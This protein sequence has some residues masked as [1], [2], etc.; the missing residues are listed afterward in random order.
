MEKN[1]AWG[2]FELSPLN[3]G[4]SDASPD[5]AAASPEKTK[6]ATPFPSRS[7]RKAR[8][9]KAAPAA[10]EPPVSS[11][12][13]PETPR[14]IELFDMPPESEIKE[15]KKKV[16]K[17]KKEK[18]QKESASAGETG[19]AG[20]KDKKG[21]KKGLVFAL[22]GGGLLA[23]A[24]IVGVI[25]ILTF[26]TH[27]IGNGNLAAR[28][29]GE[30]ITAKQLE[31]SIAKLQLNNPQIFEKNSG[32]SAAQIRDALL[33]ELINEQL[34]L[35]DAKSKGVTPSDQQVNQ[36]VEAIKKQYGSQK[37]FD[38]VL[39]K[40]GYT[41]ESLKT[42]LKYQLAAQGIAK[43][44][45]PDSAVSAK[46]AQ[47][48]FNANKQNYVVQAGKQVSQIKFALSDQAKADEVLA[49]I[50]SGGDF[51]QLAKANS[52]D[53]VTA[54][55]G[56]DLGWTPRNPPLDKTLQE[57]VN[58]MKKGDVSDVIKSST[59]LFILKVTDEREAS[60]QPFSNVEST[61]KMTL[62]NSKRNEAS[63]SLLTDLKKKAKI[64]IYDKVVKDFQDKKATAA[65][66]TSNGSKSK[67][68]GSG[69]K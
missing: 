59:G 15:K 63:R 35:Q 62:L 32:I 4:P 12:L 51:A 69:K 66:P 8:P 10:S 14:G 23:V 36:Q 27:T 44:L 9:E 29:N 50:K 46:D 13:D 68:S 64:V 26:G 42:Q 7:E 48:Y 6:S 18:T 31:A 25:L 17:P 5:K 38:D 58:G 57:A 22:I 2:E 20:A 19:E 16:K 41:I 39:R 1:D 61:I 24:A 21:P 65:S 60:E 56:G 45:V 40:Q 30:G 52:V 34:I 43:K 28:V 53:T 11:V 47:D 33:T 37:Q 54:A 55:S 67:D 3:E 49:Q